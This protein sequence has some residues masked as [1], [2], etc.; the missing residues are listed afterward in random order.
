MS[1]LYPLGLLGLIGIPVLIAVYIIKSKYTEQ[2]VSSTFLWT[3]SERFLRKKN[4]VSKLTGIISLIL[5]ILSVAIISLLI[6]H[7]IIVLPDSAN[8]YCFIIDGSASMNMQENGKSRFEDG[9]ERIASIIDESVEGSVYSLI[10]SADTTVLVYERLDDKEIATELLMELECSHGEENF[11]KAQVAAQKYFNENPSLLTYFVT[12]KP[13]R[14]NKNVTLINVSKTEQNSA[15]TDLTHIWAGETLTVEGKATSYR[16]DTTVTLE[17]YINESDTPVAT[18]SLF[19]KQAKPTPFTIVGSA[20]NFDSFR[21]KIKEEDSLSLD[22]TFCAFNPKSG[23]VYKT[24]IVSDTPFFIRS[25]IEVFLESDIDV[26]STEEYESY[27]GT[28]YGLYIFDSFSPDELPRTGAVWF[29]NPQTSVKGSGF[30]VLGRATQDN[31][32]LTLSDET[33]SFARVLKADLTGNEIRSSHYVQCSLYKNFTSIYSYHNN[34][35]IFA[36]TNDY[37]NREVVI[38]F[39]L[40]DS[41]LPLLFDYSILIRNFLNFSFPDIVEQNAFCVGEEIDINVVSGCETI[42]VE[43][44]EG[45]ISYLNTDMGVAKYVPLTVGTHTVTLIFKDKQ[46][47]IDVFVFLSESERVPNLLAKDFS[48][49]GVAESGGYDG[50]YDP[51]VV[52]FI[53]LAVI[54]FADWVVYCYEK[55]QLR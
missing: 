28:G 22:N 39:D 33:S 48:L 3:L 41:I 45:E 13:Y 44:P 32:A 42:K 31:D 55:Y 49:S 7:P 36:G 8:E 30:S 53:A 4:P 24:L 52:L 9:K 38:A 19:L 14:Q 29:I 27:T 23:T 50:K 11:S 40:H 10:Y 16:S 25:A 5:Q 51:M 34:P 2:T 20:D 26:I 46:I 21:V 47:E 43:S 15:I 35:V 18:A 1:F 54:F 6:A 37:G 17:L 12:D